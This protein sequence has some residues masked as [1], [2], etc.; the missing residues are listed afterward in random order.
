[1]PDQEQKRS[2]M[3]DQSSE[4][5]VLFFNVNGSGLG[6][7]NRCLAY[8]RRLRN[9]LR[10][11]FFSLA[12]A[13]EIIEDMGFEADYFVSHYWSASSSFSWN[14][15]LAVRF[16]LM[17]E[18]VRP[19]VVVFD[20]TWPFQGFM[21]ACNAYGAPALVWSNRGLLKAG[22]PSAPIDEEAFDLI[23]QPGELNT[24]TSQSQLGKK[25]K[26]IT[27]PPVCLLDDDEVLDRAAARE[28][29][30]LGAE[31]NY[32]LFSLGPGNLK[33]VAG[34]GHNLIRMFEVAG[35]QV[36]WARAP[37]SVR[38]VDLPSGVIPISQ[39]P[40]VRYMRAFDA[41]VGAAGYNTC[42]E[43]VQAQ[44]PSLLV[45]NAQ[46]ADDQLRRAQLVAQMAPVVVSA[47]E[48]EGDRRKSI[49]K[50][51]GMIESGTWQK[52]NLLPMNGASVAANE[53]VALAWSKEGTH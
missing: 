13:I 40:L 51:F 37:I 53:I 42:C 44:I 35:M 14:C 3:R 48:N 2:E 18:R 16:G 17:L 5:R 26:K 22:T 36:V 23:I 47:C 11:V 12:S 49:E 41:F 29:L 27:V 24:K 33:D 45:P 38:D 4:E 1:M 43:V 30:G 21:A 34:I 25:G 8:A 28:S 6:H 46:L 52:I 39:Y 10:P 32:V 7:M 19:A 50:L 9:R 20:G 15:E 31:G